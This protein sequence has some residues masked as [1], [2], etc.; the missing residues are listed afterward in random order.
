MIYMYINKMI[1]PI[2]LLAVLINTVF[3]FTLL[4]KNIYDTNNPI[5]E[6]ITKA[7]N[8]ILAIAF[9]QYAMTFVIENSNVLEKDSEL[10]AQQLRY[11]DWLITTPLLLFTY[12]KL[13]KIDGFSGDFVWL[14]F[15]DIGMMVC[16]ILSEILLPRNKRLAYFL[17]I[18]GSL[19]YVYIFIEV[20]RI[21]RFFNKTKGQN[22]VKKNRLGYFFLL[23]WSIYPIGFFLPSDFKYILYSIGDFINKG[24]YSISL[25]SI[26]QS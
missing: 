23:G 22:Y 21:M 9:T 12:W 16:G 24:L 6:Q 2:L 25:Q 15:A 18:L 20:L 1:N 7:E 3:F 11:I 10:F 17:F 14:L 19:F 13:A 4:L 5:Y 8:A 26:I